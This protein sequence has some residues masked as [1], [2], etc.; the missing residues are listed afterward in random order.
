MEFTFNNKTYELAELKE[1]NQ[2]I[3]FDIIAIFEVKTY[4]MKG[5]DEVKE[6]SRAEAKEQEKNLYKNDFWLKDKYFFINYLI[7]QFHRFY[8]LIFLIFH[9]YFLWLLRHG[10]VLN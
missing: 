4:I 6:I 3:Y 2:N 10:Y 9:I 1:P 8:L 7:F 5:F